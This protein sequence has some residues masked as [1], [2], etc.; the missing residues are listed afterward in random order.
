MA[1]TKFYNPAVDDD[2]STP[3]SADWANHVETGIFDAAATADAAIAKSVGT[4]AGDIIYFTG[5]GAPARLALGAAGTVLKGGASAPSWASI[6]NA[7]IDAAA[8]IGISKLAGY[9]SDA[10]KVL[11]GDGSWA[12][13]TAGPTFTYGT[14]PPASPGDGDIHILV[15]S[16]TAPTYQWALRYNASSTNG[17]K[18]EFIGGAPVT[19][20]TGAFGPQTPGTTFVDLSTACSI[21]VPRAGV[22][23]AE[24][25]ARAV[26][27]AG[28]VQNVTL[29]KGASAAADADG[30]N[31]SLVA[32]EVKGNR[33]LTVTG[34]SASDVLKLQVRTTVAGQAL[35]SMQAFLAVTPVRVS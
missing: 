16:A 11:Y 1:Y 13:P 28:N 9:P 22:Y 29:K 33:F 31:P 30:T 15:D 17:D 19:V 5:S 8:A 2:V 4:V 3:V 27:P 6:V 34:L 32:N 23:K 10:T 20:D 26:P 25:Y 7:D 12:V 21:T 18:W 35:A 14:T 24:F